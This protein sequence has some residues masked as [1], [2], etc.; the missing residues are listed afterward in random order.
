[1]PEVPVEQ[2]QNAGILQGGLITGLVLIL[3]SPSLANLS[4]VHN[5]FAEKSIARC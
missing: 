3:R 4:L 1:M 5:L 2:L